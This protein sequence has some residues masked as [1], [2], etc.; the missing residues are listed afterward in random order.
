MWN[1]LHPRRVSRQIWFYSNSEWFLWSQTP[2]WQMRRPQ[3]DYIPYMCSQLRQG[4]KSCISVE[5]AF[6]NTTKWRQKQ[7]SRGFICYCRGF[8]CY[9]SDQRF[10][11][12]TTEIQKVQFNWTWMILKVLC[13]WLSTDS[14][15]QLLGWLISTIDPAPKWVVFKKNLIWICV[16]S[17]SP[18]LFCSRCWWKVCVARCSQLEMRC[19]I[20]DSFMEA[21]LCG[22]L[23]I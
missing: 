14:E 3:T 2:V 17:W 13:G 8:I 7:Q 5:T 21:Q 15:T 11:V 12:T 10:S 6:R 4:R 19:K 1:H 16:K 9:C 20:M 23:S 18:V 22:L